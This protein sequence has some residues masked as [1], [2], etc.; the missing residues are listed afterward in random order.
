MVLIRLFKSAGALQGIIGII[1]GLWT[2]IWG[3]MNAAKE[4][5]KNIMMIWTGLMVLYIIL[6]ALGG[7]AA[8]ST[9]GM[10]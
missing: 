9:R 10:P 8:L 1:C 4:G 6:G 7:F 5:I 3:W 2:F